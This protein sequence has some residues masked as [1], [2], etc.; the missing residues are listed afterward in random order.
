MFD[1]TIFLC[2]QA[3]ID[4]LIFEF[5]FFIYFSHIGSKVLGECKLI[6][7]VSIRLGSLLYLHSCLAAGHLLSLALLPLYQV[8][9]TQ[10]KTIESDVCCR[11]ALINS[12]IRKD[13]ITRYNIY[14]RI[15]HFFI[16]SFF[17]IQ[18]LYVH[19]YIV[20]FLNIC[21]ICGSLFIRYT[22]YPIKFFELN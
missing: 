14:H 20:H 18:S 17:I 21:F 4:Q 13:Q 22:L 11:A 3:N 12:V 5:Y 10:P 15:G 8:Q 7:I 19:F 9:K 16:H 1:T 6:W 2:K